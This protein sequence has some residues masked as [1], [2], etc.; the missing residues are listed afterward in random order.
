MWKFGAWG[1]IS[2]SPA[3]E[4]NGTLYVG[5]VDNYVYAIKTQSYGLMNSSWPKFRG[6]DKN[7]GN[8]LE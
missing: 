3:I 4:K 7:S 1:P 2:S 8:L 5:C 6:N